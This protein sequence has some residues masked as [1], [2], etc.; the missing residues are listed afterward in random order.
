MQVSWLRWCEIKHIK[1]HSSYFLCLN[2][3]RQK[4]KEVTDKLTPKA[5]QT[6]TG[7][8]D[9]SAVIAKLGKAE[10]GGKSPKE[11]CAK[12]IE[13]RKPGFTVPR[14][15]AGPKQSQSELRK[16]LMA[17]EIE[18][19]DH[20]A[21]IPRDEG[22]GISMAEAELEEQLKGHTGGGC[23]LIQRLLGFDD[24]QKEAPFRMRAAA[25]MRQLGVATQGVA[26]A[27]ISTT[28]QLQ[29]ATDSPAELLA[30]DKEEQAV[31]RETKLGVK[32][33]G[34]VD[35]HSHEGS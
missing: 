33:G 30:V 6:S 11:T 1:K 16:E 22:G 19:L 34:S 25:P 7:F 9:A 18:R 8:Y 23:A 29:P 10:K 26:R 31:P 17:L 2:S 3:T 5:P 12:E 14:N 35:R 13:L 24:E 4:R 27:P 32:A 28:T 21:K 15:A 20:D